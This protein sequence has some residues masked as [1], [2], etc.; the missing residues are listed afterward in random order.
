MLQFEG[1]KTILDVRDTRLR[2]SAY[3]ENHQSAQSPWKEDP[4]LGIPNF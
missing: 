3:P 1:E 2:V 4:S